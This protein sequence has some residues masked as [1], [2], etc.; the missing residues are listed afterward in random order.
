MKYFYLIIALTWFIQIS[1]IM[2]LWW[3]WV[4]RSEMND[5]RSFGLSILSTVFSSC[6]VVN[7]IYTLTEYHF[8][9]D[10]LS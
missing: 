9:R 7:L 8:I 6:A 10:L 2:S 1:V 5:A 3:G 4:K